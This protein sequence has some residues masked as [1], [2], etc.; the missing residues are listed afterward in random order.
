MLRNLEPSAIVFHPDR[1]AGLLKLWLLSGYFG[2]GALRRW[3]K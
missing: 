2:T 1:V 3:R